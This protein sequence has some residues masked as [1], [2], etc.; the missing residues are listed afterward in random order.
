[1]PVVFLEHEVFY[2]Y[3]FIFSYEAILVS[4]LGWG[5]FVIGTFFCP[6]R[7]KQFQ[8][9]FNIIPKSEYLIGIVALVITLFFVNYYTIKMYGSIPVLQI[10]QK[11]E[12]INAYNS[13]QSNS[14]GILGV[15]HLV[16][17]LSIFFIARFQ[18]KYYKSYKLI[19]FSFYGLLLFAILVD[20]KR[21]M[22]FIVLSY[23]V[24]FF[25]IQSQTCLTV[26]FNWKKFGIYSGIAMFF[27][28]LMGVSRAGGD[29]LYPFIHYLSLPFIN[30]MDIYNHVPW[31][32]NGEWLR[33][34]IPNFS[35]FLLD[36]LNM[37][38][39]SNYQT[40]EPT[41]GGGIMGSSYLI[42]GIL[43]VFIYLFIL[44]LVMQTI[45]LQA[46]KN[47]YFLTVYPLFAW[48]MIAVSSHDHFRNTM[49]IIIPIILI[50]SVLALYRILAVGQN[51]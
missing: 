20:G 8:C 10:F 41:I 36:V 6:I 30:Y 2:Y 28:S 49:F 47:K 50:L 12:N 46:Y 15:K 3:D 4:V 13:L 31:L 34:F 11:V 19:T 44:G 26:K 29:F 21:Q 18:N 42:G 35:H 51:K 1:M 45:Y 7:S 40:L 33:M 25:Y 32:G 37:T 16:I 38:P 24:V 39:G 22:V 23:L 48:P 17:Y 5:W 27:F 14:N 9:Q 43:G